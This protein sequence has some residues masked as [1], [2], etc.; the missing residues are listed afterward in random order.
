MSLLFFPKLN[1]ESLKSYDDTTVLA[2]LGYKQEQKR[3]FTTLEMFGFGFSIVAIVPSIASVLF[4][5]TPSDGP[6]AMWA[7]SSVFIMFIALTMAELGS[8]APTSGTPLHV[9]E[10]LGGLYYW[11][12]KYS[13][14]RYCN[15]LCLVIGYTNTVTYIS[16]VAGIGCSCAT[17]VMAA[18]SISSDGNFIPTVNQ[19]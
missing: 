10:N 11:T 3:E 2:S 12:Y 17:A 5:S 16:G 1:P 13:S 6:S 14:P 18:A 8:A 7:V 4:N 15:I 9:S 19:T